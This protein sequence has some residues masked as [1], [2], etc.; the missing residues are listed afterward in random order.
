MGSDN[1][2][3]MAIGSAGLAGNM[4]IE[5][6]APVFKGFK[7]SLKSN[8]AMDF[9]PSDDA[10]MDYLQ[11]NG[12]EIITTSNNTDYVVPSDKAEAFE[13]SAKKDPNDKSLKSLGYKTFDDVKPGIL[14]KYIVPGI[15]PTAGAI[16]GA[17]PSVLGG[18]G[19][20]ALGAGLGAAT[21]EG[22]NRLIASALGVPQTTRELVTNIGLAAGGGAA[23]PIIGESLHAVGKFASPVTSPIVE[24]AY[25]KI[26][27]PLSKAAETYE[28]ALKTPIAQKMLD[29]AIGRGASTVK[30]VATG[31]GQKLANAFN[32]RLPLG[33]TETGEI[34]MVNPLDPELYGK[35]GTLT[36][37]EL[38]QGKSYP[39]SQFREQFDEL[40]QNLAYSRLTPGQQREYHQFKKIYEIANRN[41]LAKKIAYKSGLL[42]QE[43]DML[44]N[45]ISPIDN[46]K[47]L[48]F[49]KEQSPEYVKTKPS[50][51]LR[52]GE[53]QQLEDLTDKVWN[54]LSRSGSTIRPED[55]TRIP[56]AQMRKL[57]STLE[58]DEANIIKKF[59]E[60][61][62][63]IGRYAKNPPSLPL[64]SQTV[65]RFGGGS[66]MLGVGVATAPTTVRRTLR[67]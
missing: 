49:M 21:G 56:E 14:G 47:F 23:S 35:L 61:S 33:R 42:K 51:F 5:K 12:Y 22:A 54:L 59:L 8:L 24:T 25:S 39:S 58:P 57:L 1:K 41:P 18:P 6:V 16:L 37:N 13:T 62:I 40:G 52:I 44:E 27:Q 2:K 48:N 3:N 15:L 45:E 4:A 55:L 67:E 31:L 28:T 66:P 43:L 20:M 9:A 53:E 36:E 65:K 26:G 64:W 11:K 19:A 34:R 29:T 30:E 10:I 17:A 60:Q 7:N 63:D 50:A 32:P 46:M 38:A